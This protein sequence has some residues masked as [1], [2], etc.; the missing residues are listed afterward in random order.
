MIFRVTSMINGFV[1]LALFWIIIF[2]I[3]LIEMELK[4]WLVDYIQAYMI[5]Q[6]SKNSSVA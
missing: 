5:S 2:I 1:W 3:I 6:Q 4:I